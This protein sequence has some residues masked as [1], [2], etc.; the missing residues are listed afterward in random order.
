MAE[1]EVYDWT[2]IF[3]VSLYDS[4]SNE[5][6]Y[7]SIDVLKGNGSGGRRV[8]HYT[9]D[10]SDYEFS[11]EHIAAQLYSHISKH[12]TFSDWHDIDNIMR[13]NNYRQD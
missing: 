1:M 7:L 12:S 4:G 8:Y 13:R 5:A 3:H 6:S 11:A 2:F 9:L 10:S